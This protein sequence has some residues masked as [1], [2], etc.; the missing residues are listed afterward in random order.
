[1]IAI[2][3]ETTDQDFGAVE[4]GRRTLCCAIRYPIT[5][6]FS[7]GAIE[8]SSNYDHSAFEPTDVPLQDWQD[9]PDPQ[10][11][12]K[13]QPKMASDLKSLLASTSSTLM[14]MGGSMNITFAMRIAATTASTVA[15]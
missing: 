1:M 12:V 9:D 4:A 11:I 15:L 8:M 3:T 14:P 13:T 5:S 10:E 6:K 2:W 7:T